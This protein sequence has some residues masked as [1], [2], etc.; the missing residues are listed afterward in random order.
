MRNWETN[1]DVEL[2]AMAKRMKDK[3]DKYWRNVEKMNMLLYV[4]SVLDPTK[5]LEF[6][7][8]CFKKMY[9]PEQSLMMIHNV[10]KTIEEL[11]DDY[12]K[13]LQ[14]LSE[15]VGEVAK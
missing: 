14:P 2:N 3:F 13:R 12:K 8:F 1:S 15:Q 9:D 11:F 5:K 4:A 10:E 7:R 6:V